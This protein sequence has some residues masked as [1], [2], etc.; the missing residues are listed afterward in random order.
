MTATIEKANSKVSSVAGIVGG[1]G[2]IS[3][4]VGGAI[5]YLAGFFTLPSDVKSLKDELS[6]LRLVIAAQQN[7]I[8]TGLR[9]PQGDRGFVGPQGPT[10]ERGPP[11]PAGPAGALTN[12][13]QQELQALVARV[14][15]ENPSASNSTASGGQPA[16]SLQ[17]TGLQR[18][19]DGCILLPSRQLNIRVVVS[20]VAKF[21]ADNRSQQ[22]D[23]FAI[24]ATRNR[25]HWQYSPSDQRICN[26][27]DVCTIP[28]T[29][30]YR[31]RIA[32]FPN[33]GN[34]VELVFFRP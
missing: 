23:M 17:I 7:R 20:A 18:Q 30:E 34:S 27:G 9:G 33:G 5:A 3:A 11:G 12:I 32:S 14:I 28:W 26:S 31:Y 29:N 22:I 25:I 8:D 10:G 2:T 13:S 4:F 1:L 15:A 24:E 19:S 6:Q 21:C 16:S